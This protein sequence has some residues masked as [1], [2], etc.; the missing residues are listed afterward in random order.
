MFEIFFSAIVGYVFGVELVALFSSRLNTKALAYGFLYLLVLSSLAAA[1]YELDFFAQKPASDFSF[2]LFEARNVMVNPTF[3]LQ[4]IVNLPVFVMTGKWWA[5]IGTN[6]ALMAV[7]FY[8]VFDRAP[9]LSLILLA[10]AIVNFSMFALRDPIIGVLFFLFML[11][12]LSPHQKWSSFWQGILALSFLAIRPENF[13][14]VAYSKLMTVLNQWRTSIV[15][16]L[17]L[18]FILLSGAGLVMLAPKM[19][20]VDSGNSVSELS[21]AANDFYKNRADRNDTAGSNILNGRL[22][23]MPVYLRYPIQVLTFFVLPLP[24]EIRQL[25][26][27]LAFVDSIVFCSLC[28]FFHRRCNANAIILFWIYVLAVSFFASNYGNVFRIRLPTYFI[29]LGAFLE[30]AIMAKFNSGS[31]DRYETNEAS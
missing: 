2:K 26:L 9:K 8:Y 31:H 11:P 29:M 18:P 7:A 23:A 19:V 21:G 22:T 3:L 25:S 17:L 1:N 13:V 16:Y 6:V 12:F 15:T 28:Y 14:I 30:P 24:F 20:G 10:P 4:T 5:A 27:A